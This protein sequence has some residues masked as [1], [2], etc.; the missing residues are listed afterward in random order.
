MEARDRIC[1][2]PP[3]GP[4]HNAWHHLHRTKTLRS[5]RAKLVAFKLTLSFG[6]TVDYLNKA[7]KRLQI[8]GLD[9]AQDSPAADCTPFGRG[10]LVSAEDVPSA[11]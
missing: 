2:S 7:A 9:E 1:Q 5:E 3:A 4:G 6:Y 10:A 8:L 11:L